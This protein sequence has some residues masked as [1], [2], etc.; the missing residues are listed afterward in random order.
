M[1]SKQ[2]IIAC[3]A[4]MRNPLEHA[5]NRLKQAF[6]AIAKIEAE[7][8]SFD[9]RLALIRQLENHFGTIQADMERAKMA[10]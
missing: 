9:E 8:T 5:Q 1:D 4:N 3:C 7:G 10:I 2:M 6:E